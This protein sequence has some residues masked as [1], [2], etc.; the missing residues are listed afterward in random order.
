MKPVS[1]MFACAVILA[2]AA[3]PV[4]AQDSAQIAQFGEGHHALIEQVSTAGNNSATIYQGTGW[5][6]GYGNQASVMQRNVDSSQVE[7]HQAGGGN[8]VMVAQYDGWN[9]TAHVNVESG[10]RGELGGYDNSVMIEQTGFDS[11]ASVD[12]GSSAYSRA[13]IRQSGMGWGDGSGNRAE[14]LQSGANNQASIQQSGSNFNAMI[15]Q[16]NPGY[17]NSYGN[18]AF[19]RQTH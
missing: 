1:S 13:E 3:S 16:G 5:Y 15:V 14:I 11:F 12:Q 2:C 10:W 8:N 7:V 9:L 17:G 19:I 4:L 18:S 6:S